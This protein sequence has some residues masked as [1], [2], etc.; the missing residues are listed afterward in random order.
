MTT[1]KNC[2]SSAPHGHYRKITFQSFNHD[3]VFQLSIC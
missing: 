2:Y 3:G 1:K